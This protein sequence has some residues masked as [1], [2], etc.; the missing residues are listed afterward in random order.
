VHPA[1]RLLLVVPAAVA[2]AGAGLLGSFVHPLSVAVLPVGL[3]LGFVLSAAV[4][5]TAG[6]LLGRPG[7]AA[8]AL[9]WLVV[10]LL[11]AARRPEGDLVVPGSAAG[12]VWLLGGTVLAGVC[13]SLPYSSRAGRPMTPPWDSTRL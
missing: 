8:A 7:A 6:L 10:V 13:A 4:F 9:G 12:Y 11:L 3:A 1:V 2:G 5:V